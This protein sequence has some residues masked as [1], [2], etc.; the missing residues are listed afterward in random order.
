MGWLPQTAGAQSEQGI[1]W[2][3]RKAGEGRLFGVAWS[4]SLFVAVGQNTALSSPDGLSW[5]PVKTL[6]TNNLE[7]I[8]WGKAQFVAV[9]GSPGSAAPVILASPDGVTWTQRS[10]PGSKALMDIA[11]SE[12]LFVAVGSDTILTS[13]DAVTW[14]EQSIPA[15][16]N[17]FNSVI[18]AG[19]QFIAVGRTQGSEPMIV[20]LPDGKGGMKRY[21]NP[22]KH[23]DAGLISTSL[24]GVTW[25][26][27]AVSASETLEDIA[28]SGDQF[29][30]VG[31][32]T[33]LTSPDAITWIE[34]KSPV[35]GQLISVTW[36]GSQFVAVGRTQD[37]SNTMIT[38]P[39]ILTS[40]DGVAWGRKPPPT[41]GSLWEIVW[42]GTRFVAVGQMRS[43]T[44]YDA[45]IVTSP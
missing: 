23:A 20:T 22:A 13:S 45:L 34:Q 25:T 1:Q 37:T 2:T 40:P 15:V 3:H 7:A 42:G 31:G 44:W 43:R 38:I 39:L 41:D 10:A 26:R 32:N 4:G 19:N 35:S 16:D 11:C 12:E 28:W 5:K 21:I 6:S 29:V 18:W 30:S 36:S 14:S 17:G 8:T 27:R 9:G 33:I 24:D